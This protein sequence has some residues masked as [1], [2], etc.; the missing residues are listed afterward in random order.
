MKLVTSTLTAALLTPGAWGLIG[1][2]IRM[3][4]PYCAHACGRAIEPAPLSCSVEGHD[5]G[6]HME[7]GAVITTAMCRSSDPSF[8]TTLAWCMH[9][10]CQVSHIK[11]WKLEKY[12]SIQATGDSTVP[13]KWTYAQALNATIPPV[14]SLDIEQTINGTMELPF[15]VW[16]DQLRT[17]K[18][19]EHEETLHSR[20]GY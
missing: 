8:L 10:R 9:E 6:M 1:Y 4:D 20:Y 11:V 13:P 2:G 17:L 15:E 3:Y 7:G 5:H 16:N 19:F 14:N 18:E 12:W